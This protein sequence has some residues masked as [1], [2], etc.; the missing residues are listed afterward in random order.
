MARVSKGEGACSACAAILRDASLR[1]APQDEDRSA[2]FAGLLL[3]SFAFPLALVAVA[4]VFVGV[5]LPL[6]VV[7]GAAAG[8]LVGEA[9]RGIELLLTRHHRPP[10]V[11]SSPTSIDFD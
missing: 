6:D 4:R 5:H 1:D 8:L 9:A 10:A 2:A 3:M 7:G 11:A